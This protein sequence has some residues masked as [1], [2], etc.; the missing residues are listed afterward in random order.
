MTA[1]AIDAQAVDCANDPRHKG[2]I[3]VILHIPAERGELLTKVLG[4][5]TYTTPVPVA[6]ARLDTGAVAPVGGDASG[7]HSPDAS[8]SGRGRPPNRYAQRAGILCNDPRFQGFLLERYGDGVK[9]INPVERREWAAQKVRELC[10]VDSRSEIIAGTA[11]ADRF[12][13]LDANYL[14]ET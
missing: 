6:L 3:R 14:A 10:E 5:P 9:L 1:A 8:A 7:S 4:W 2:F 11:A 13:E 12:E